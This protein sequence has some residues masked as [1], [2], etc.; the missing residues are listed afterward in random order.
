MGAG[1]ECVIVQWK[2]PTS[3]NDQQPYVI[4]WQNWQEKS[5]DVRIYAE[6][7][8]SISDRTAIHKTRYQYKRPYEV[9][10]FPVFVTLSSEINIIMRFQC[11]GHPM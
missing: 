10:G 1:D 9:V 2:V 7:G 6:G 11:K 3:F 8:L 4:N 5:A